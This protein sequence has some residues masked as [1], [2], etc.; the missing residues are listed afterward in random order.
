VKA[1][2]VVFNIT[3]HLSSCTKDWEQTTS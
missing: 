1:S 3:P 2:K